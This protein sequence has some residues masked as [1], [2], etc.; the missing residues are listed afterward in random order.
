[1]DNERRFAYFMDYFAYH[2]TKAFAISAIIL[3]APF[4]YA[5]CHRGASLLD[6]LI[7]LF[8]FSINAYLVFNL[9]FARL[10]RR[11][12]E[13]SPRQI[14]LQRALTET[15]TSIRY[16]G[17][18]E[19]LINYEL[20]M[21]YKDELD[22]FDIP[23]FLLSVERHRNIVVAISYHVVG[24]DINGETKY[25][26]ISRVINNSKNFSFAHMNGIGNNGVF[27]E[28]N[29]AATIMEG[30]RKDLSEYESGLGTM[31]FNIRRISPPE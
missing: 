12:W 22:Q 7:I 24:E 15:G 20:I 1:M 26:T 31:S 5:V 28:I 3:S 23:L 18:S 14:D 11:L 27:I 2:K 19:N 30:L 8:I 10:R 29:M 25:S 13:A 4:A 6:V 16:Y 9:L 17:C 21:P